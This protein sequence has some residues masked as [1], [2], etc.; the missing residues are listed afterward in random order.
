LFRDAQCYVDGSIMDSFQN[1]GAGVPILVAGPRAQHAAS[2]LARLGLSVR[3]VGD[4]VGTASAIKMC[5]SI[6]TK[7]AECLFVE[8]LLA[9]ERYA[10]TEEVLASIEASITDG[11]F[12]EWVNMLVTTHAIHAGRRGDEMRKIVEVLEASGMA[13]LLSRAAYER[14]R[15]TAE[16]GIRERLGGTV[17]HS[18]S[19]VIAALRTRS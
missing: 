3:C 17:P 9:A 12:R 2:A 6:F 5:R 14:L 16:S 4:K 11:P 7:G 1:R 8:T 18:M 19:E 10:A 13:P 15:L